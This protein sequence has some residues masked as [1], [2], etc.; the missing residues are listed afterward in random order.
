M[1]LDSGSEAVVDALRHDFKVIIF[2]FRAGDSQ[3]LPSDDQS[4]DAVG[5]DAV[6]VGAIG[7]RADDTAL[8]RNPIWLIDDRTARIEMRAPDLLADGIGGP[9]DEDPAEV[10]DH[11]SRRIR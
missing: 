2:L 8:S 6:I 11:Y 1:I 4:A 3:I 7:V 5:G 9:R 10:I